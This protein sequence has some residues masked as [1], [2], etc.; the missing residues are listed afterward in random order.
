MQFGLLDDE[1][2]KPI[3]I[4]VKRQVYKRAGGKCESCGMPLTMSHGDF[5]HTRKP[6]I[7]PTA[8]T[9]QFL[10]PTCHRIH[11]HKRKTRVSDRGTIFEE[12]STVIKRRKAPVSKTS[13]TTKTVKKKTLTRKKPTV[14]RKTTKRKTSTSK[15]TKKPVKRKTIR[16]KTTTKKTTGKRKRVP[17]ERD[18]FGD[19]IRWKY[20]TVKPKSTTKKKTTKKKRKRKSDSFFDW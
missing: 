9:V 17:A 2:R 8:K 19:V 16:K 1:K 4:T 7:S 13:K 10:C 5:H 20:V 18:I 11:G 6:S 12:K 3:K 15:T 14:K